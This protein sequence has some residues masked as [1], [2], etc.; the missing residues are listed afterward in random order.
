M[1]LLDVA[2]LLI[3]ASTTIGAWRLG[4]IARLASWLGIGIGFFVAL[5]AAPPVVRTFGSDEPVTRVFITAL[6]FLGLAGVGAILGELAGLTL[7]RSLPLGGFRTLDHLGGAVFG[8]LVAAAGFWLTLPVL[9]EVPGALSRQVRTSTLAALVGDVAPAPPDAMQ[10]LRRLVSNSGFPQVF[11][12]LRPAPDTGPPPAAPGMSQAVVSRVA[13]STV[14]V[15]GEGCGGQQEGSGFS[16]RANLVVTNAHVI[17]GTRNIT[18]LRPDGKE[19]PATPVL[20]DPNR[21]L[22]LLRVANLGQEALPV[23]AGKAGEVGAVFGHPGGQVQLDVSPAR[24]T[25]RVQARGKDIYGSQTTLREVFFLAARLA[26]GDS[27]GAL[28]NA[29]GDVIGVAFAISPDRSDTAYA[30][31]DDELNAVLAQPVGGAVATGR[32]TR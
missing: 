15:T 6:V 22:A 7:R 29:D 1:N 20:F 28:V 13:R 14:R 11:E 32:C 31:A 27:G 2:L 23:A 8:A 12:D 3:L 24:V 26:P 16:P 18:V 10:T 19:L 5:R 17:A 4:L 21:D 25:E 30:L 9:A